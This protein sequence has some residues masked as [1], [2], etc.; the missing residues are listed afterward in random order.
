MNMFKRWKGYKKVLGD[1][2]NIV[3][4]KQNRY[5]YVYGYMRIYSAYIAIICSIYEIV[6]DINILYI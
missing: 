1:K 3:Y 6:Y 4:N 5:V 2:Y